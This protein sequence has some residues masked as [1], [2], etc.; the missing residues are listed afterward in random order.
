M[1]LSSS[2][3]FFTNVV[4]LNAPNLILKSSIQLKIEDC[5]VVAEKNR[6]WFTGSRVA[7]EVHHQMHRQREN[8]VYDEVIMLLIIKQVIYDI[9]VYGSLKIDVDL[10]QQYTDSTSHFC[11]CLRFSFLSENNIMSNH[12]YMSKQGSRI[13]SVVLIPWVLT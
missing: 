9:Y 1:F 13:S 6:D 5:V 4:K 3:L 2:E 12:L 8:K 7:T 11:F 10:L